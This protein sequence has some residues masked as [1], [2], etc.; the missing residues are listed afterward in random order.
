MYQYLSFKQLWP[1]IMD[2]TFCDKENAVYPTLSHK[3]VKSH[4]WLMSI[5]NTAGA[6]DL[7]FTFYLI[8]INLNSTGG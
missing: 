6:E 5:W 2:R 7:N 4:M 1:I 8:L 3:V